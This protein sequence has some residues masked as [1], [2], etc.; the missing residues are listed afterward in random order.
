MQIN[1]QE[2]RTLLKSSGIPVYRDAAPTNQ[3]DYPYIIY[4]FVNE[5][6]KNASNSVIYHKPLYFIAIV[7][8]GTESDYLPLQKVLEDAKVPYEDF[9]SGPFEE[10]NDSRITQYITYIRCVN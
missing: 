10:E 8:D 4:E 2:L 9:I 3:E 5:A 6:K 1:F 7:S